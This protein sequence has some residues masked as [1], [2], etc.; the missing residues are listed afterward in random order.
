MKLMGQ[1]F[2]VIPAIVFFDLLQNNTK[3]FLARFVPWPDN[4]RGGDSSK[5]QASAINSKIRPY[6]GSLLKRY[7]PREKSYVLIMGKRE[8]KVTFDHAVASLQENHA[9]V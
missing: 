2:G 5:L 6:E 9:P 7:A 4:L 8:P 1:E 3:T